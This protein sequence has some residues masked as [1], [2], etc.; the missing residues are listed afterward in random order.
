VEQC[1]GKLKGL[2]PLE[3]VQLQAEAYEADARSAAVRPS[4]S[5]TAREVDAK[6][7]AAPRALPHMEPMQELRGGLAICAN[8]RQTL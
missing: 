6:A 8:N 2:R 1:T 7:Q 5:M 4:A 3:R